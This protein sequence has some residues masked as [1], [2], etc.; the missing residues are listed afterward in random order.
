MSPLFFVHFLPFLHNKMYQTNLV[1]SLPQPFLQRTFVLL[2]ENSVFNI[3]FIYLLETGEGREKNIDVREKHWSVASCMRPHRESNQQPVCLSGK[4]PTNWTIWSGLTLASLLRII[5][6]RSD[7]IVNFISLIF[8][9]KL[10][11]STPLYSCTT[12]SL[13][14]HPSKDIKLIPVFGNDEKGIV[15]NTCIESFLWIYIF[16]ILHKCLRLRASFL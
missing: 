5:F 4:A 15:T 13:P 3:L 2:V 16:I 12:I 7:H 9:F 10:Q 1:V 6:L 14:I 8:S 11:S